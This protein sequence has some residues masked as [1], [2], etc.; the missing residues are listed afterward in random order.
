MTRK[1][2]ITS[3]AK[4]ANPWDVSPAP[5]IILDMSCSVAM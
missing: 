5:N 4:G 3:N 1:L 2:K